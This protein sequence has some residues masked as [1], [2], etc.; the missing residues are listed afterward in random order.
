MR[1][2]LVAIATNKYLDLVLNMLKS[3]SEHFMRGHDVGYILFTN[4][5][6]DPR[7][8]EIANL[9]AVHCEHTPWPGPALQRYRLLASQAQRLTTF[10]YVFYVDADME[11]V[12]DVGNEVLGTLVGTRHPFFYTR[13]HRIPIV[14]PRRLPFER[15]RQTLSIPRAC[16]RGRQRSRHRRDL[17]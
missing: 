9:V 14:G 16:D 6:D 2:A 7:L 15:V 5:D 3:A 17:A 12:G 10:D 11:F 8:R 1:V 4:R 13:R